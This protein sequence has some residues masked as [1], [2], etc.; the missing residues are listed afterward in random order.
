MGRNIASYCVSN[1]K[2]HWNRVK[3][4]GCIGTPVNVRILYSAPGFN[5]SF[6]TDWI[7]SVNYGLNFRVW[8]PDW[9]INTNFFHNAMNCSK[10]WNNCIRIYSHNIITGHCFPV[11]SECSSI[12][13]VFISRNDNS[14]IN[15]H[16]ISV[17][18]VIARRRILPVFRRHWNAN[19]FKLSSITSL[20]IIQYILQVCFNLRTIS[21]TGRIFTDEQSF[22]IKQF[23]MHI[24]MMNYIIRKYI[25]F[26]IP[27]NAKEFIHDCINF[28]FR[29]WRIFSQN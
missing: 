12:V 22:F 4:H 2:I 17:S 7:R 5:Q 28:C 19:Y 21:N 10:W 15:Y 6:Y 13:L 24:N 14:F 8:N 16:W 29:F 25:H 23:H 27:V 3:S 20:K 11:N 18:S 26:Y 1:A 9:I